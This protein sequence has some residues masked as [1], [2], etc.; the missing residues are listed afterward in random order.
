MTTIVVRAPATG[1]LVGEVP[2]ASPADVKEA[3]QAARAA[4]KEWGAL[5]VRERCRRLKAFRKALADRMGELQDLLVREGGKTATDAFAETSGIFLASTYFLTKAPSALRDRRLDAFWTS[6]FPARTYYHPRGVVAIIAPWNYPFLIPAYETFCALVAGNAVVLKPSEWTPLVA[7]KVKEVWDGTGLPRDL[8]RVVQ[9]YGDVGAALIDALPDKVHF[10]GAVRTGKKVAAACGERLIPCTLELGGK[11]PAI[12]L[13]DADLERA[14]RTIVWGRF[15]N[16]GQTCI[17]VERVY[18]VGSI[19]EPLARRLVELTKELRQGDASADIGAMVFPAQ[20]DHVERLVAQA[21][22]AGARV[23]TG[24]ARAAGPGRFFEPTILTNVRQDMDV[25][26]EEAF[27]PVLPIVRVADTEEAVRL[28][29]DSTLGLNAYVFAPSNRK[30]VEVAK[31]VRAGTVLVNDV[32]VNYALAAIPFGGVKESGIGRSH[33]V[34]GLRSMCEERVVAR[35]LLARFPVSAL[36]RYPYS[37]AWTK[38]LE[39]VVRR[40]FGSWKT[41]DSGAEPRK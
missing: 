12:V 36:F 30:G 23:E 8:L 26:R 37:P 25:I 13:E 41:G 39:N 15:F 24:G 17:A 6:F 14:A 1:D 38:K 10:T 22:E 2:V 31:R 28:A 34:E 4:Q 40:V 21:K 3:V 11:A 19:A 9:G 20:V 16:S 29:N 33:G 7:A 35:P 5:R 27:G 18:A 32:I